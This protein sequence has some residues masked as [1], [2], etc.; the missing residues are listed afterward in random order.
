MTTRAP[1]RSAPDWIGRE[2]DGFVAVLLVCVLVF[3]ALPFGRLLIAALAPGGNFNPAATFAAATS[4]TAL[5]AAWHTIE[6]GVASGIG[7][8]VLGAGF[9]IVLAITDVRGK[10]MLALLFVMSLLVAPQVTALAYQTLAGPAS[11]LLNAIG[12]APAPGTPNPLLGRFGVILILSLHHAPLAAI[13]VAVG[14]RAIPASLIEA[15]QLDGAKPLAMLGRIILPLL[16]PHL[17]MAALLVFVAG[18]GNF[19]IP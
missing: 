12:L 4:R 8:F 2:G 17:I 14:V 11:P 9:A 7:A 1:A 3:A 13:T 16:R 5:I 10:R 15:A 6:T 18:V 19:G